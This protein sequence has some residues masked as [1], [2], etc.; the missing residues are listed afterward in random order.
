MMPVTDDDAI[1]TTCS[2]AR[3]DDTLRQAMA[4]GQAVECT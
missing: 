4:L 1:D 3:G 2:R